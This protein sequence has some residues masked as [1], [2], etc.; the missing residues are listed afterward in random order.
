MLGE[1]RNQ[2]EIEEFLIELEKSRG[3]RMAFEYTEEDKKMPWYKL[4]FTEYKVQI[5][6]IDAYSDTHNDIFGHYGD[7]DRWANEMVAVRRTI[8]E[9]ALMRKMGIPLWLSDFRKSSQIYDTIIEHLEYWRRRLESSIDRVSPPL[10]DMVTLNDFAS[11]LVPTAR[12]YLDK[13]KIVKGRGFLDIV[14]NVK[15]RHTHGGEID[16]RPEFEHSNETI[17]RI[18]HKIHVTS[19]LLST[20][21]QPD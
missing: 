18:A 16:Y 2:R 11:E 17:N 9:M 8:V 3:N 19:D 4:F 7:T 12:Q 14:N 6:Q 1:Y 5:R 13:S 15:R 20:Y 21:D 10:E